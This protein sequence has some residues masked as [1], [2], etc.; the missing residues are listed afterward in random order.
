MNKNTFGK[1]GKGVHSYRICNIAIVDLLLTIIASYI[2]AIAFKKSFVDI[3]IGLFIIGE[4]L[5][6]YYGVDTTI[7]KAIKKL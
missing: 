3:F 6:L 7:A 2:L 1:P 5:H 4:L